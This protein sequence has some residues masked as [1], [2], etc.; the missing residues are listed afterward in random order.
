MGRRGKPRTPLKLLVASGSHKANGRSEPELQP[1][2][3]PPPEFLSESE[4]AMWLATCECIGV[5]L[6]RDNWPAML[7]L[8]TAHSRLVR[9][10]EAGEPREESRASNDMLRAARELGMTPAARTSVSAAATKAD[11]PLEAFLKK[12]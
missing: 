7:M 8:V 9:A 12:G 6:T 10:I 4:R 5:V 2:V 1:G 11:D 3:P